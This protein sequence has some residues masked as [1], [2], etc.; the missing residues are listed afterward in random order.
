MKV[1]FT[2]LFGSLAIGSVSAI[3]G[4]KQEPPRSKPYTCNVR[5]SADSEAVCGCALVSSKHV[6]TTATCVGQGDYYVSLG[7]FFNRGR[8]DGQQLKVVSILKHP[9]YEDPG[10]RNDF[11][12]LTLDGTSNYAPVQL[13]MSEDSS[14]NLKTGDWVTA[15]GWGGTDPS[16]GYGYSEVLQRVELEVWESE[17]C[18]NTTHF[19]F[20]DRTFFCAG[21]EK[22]KGVAY[23][24]HG[25]P[26][27]LKNEKGPDDDVLI[28]LVSRAPDN[29]LDGIPAVCARVSSVRD[30]VKSNTITY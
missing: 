4:G 30:W 26:V 1:I 23:G 14:K 2:A 13:P 27:I 17:R 7:T 12:I 11:A 22:G 20:I 6:L 10:R 28:G 16:N 21:G 9:K 15:M 18:R 19:D 8:E 25:G 3:V 5:F 29:N 24:D